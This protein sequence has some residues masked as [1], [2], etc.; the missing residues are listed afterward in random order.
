MAEI[1][2]LLLRTLVVFSC[3]LSICNCLQDAADNNGNFFTVS[4]F[5]YPE[6]EVRPYDTRYIRVDLPP[7][8]SSLNVAIE[9]DVDITA[10]SIS[11]ISKSLLPVICFRDGS[12]PLPDASTNALQGLELGR[13]FNGSFERAQ[14]SEIAQQCYPMQKNITLRLTNEQISPGAWYVGLFNGI[15]ATRTQGKMVTLPL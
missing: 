11:K 2:F 9:S 15:G 12:P 5:R 1:L 3:A 8:F 10:K 14:D 6:S 4:S 13:F 7:W